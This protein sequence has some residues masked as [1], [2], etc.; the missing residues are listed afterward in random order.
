M[1]LIDFGGVLDLF[2]RDTELDYGSGDNESLAH[3]SSHNGTGHQSDH[4]QH[5][6]SG[7]VLFLFMSF[8][9]GGENKSRLIVIVK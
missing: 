6:N 2:V 3:N 7:T 1:D 4:N 5:T 8:A 9:V